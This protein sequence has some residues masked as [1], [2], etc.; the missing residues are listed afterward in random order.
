MW[1]PVRWER[2]IVT[3]LRSVA[4]KALARDARN[5]GDVLVSTVEF[6]EQ[7]FPGGA[8]LLRNAST[9]WFL[10]LRRAAVLGR[11]RVTL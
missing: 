8:P 3:I 7:L 2:T 10:T 5:G 1:A 6:L 4:P 11:L 9:L